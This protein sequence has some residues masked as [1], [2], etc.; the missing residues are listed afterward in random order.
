[1]NT[2]FLPE[3]REMLQ[4]NDRA[5]LEEF[6]TAL[7]PGRTAEYM[8]GLEPLES[9]Q[10]LQ[11]TDLENRVQIFG[12][13]DAERQ[14]Q[15]VESGDP[16]PLSEL[17]AE[18]PSDDR[19][20]L[21]NRVDP[22]I[23]EAML[24]LIPTEERRDILRLSQ[25]PEGTA[26]AVMTTEVAKLSEDLTIT[27]ALQEISQQAKGLETVYYIY[28]VDEE[29]HLRGLVSARD[30]VTRLGKPETRLFEIMERDLVT[31]GVDDD[32]EHVAEKV[33]AFD[34]LAI[35]VVDHE[36]HLLGIITHDDVIDVLRE[37]AEEDAYRAAA[38]EPLQDSYMQ[39]AFLQLAW[40]RG[41][42][43][44]VLFGTALFSAYVLQ[45]YEGHINQITWLVFFIPLIMSSGGNTGGQSATLIIRALSNKDI[46][47]ADSAIVVWR[48]IQTGVVLGLLLAALG[49]LVGVLLLDEPT[50]YELM[51]VPITLLTV[52]LFGAF[53]GAT[54]PL[55]FRR[56][57]LDEALMSTP[58]VTVLIDI[59]G[60]IIYM[61]IASMLI[62]GL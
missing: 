30:L 11:A 50:Q 27:A 16:E 55:L 31:V 12:F 24:P 29:D 52:V 22:Q 38:V 10:V 60:I 46:T 19:V 4:T 14:V 26:G 36:Q 39:T 45:H 32:Q 40:N 35:P 28:I 17:I 44:T 20:D 58:F 51:V 23:V 25:H 34:F 33:A 6:C 18:M 15:I 7:H 56:L 59:G 49:Y 3:I 37:E 53:C 62:K 43:L 41:I 1:M 9:W 61:T 21:L 54:L 2:L 42:W 47:L 13:L 48:E 5:G 57:G 8:E